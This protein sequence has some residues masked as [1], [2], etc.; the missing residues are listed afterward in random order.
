MFLSKYS[1]RRI[2][3][4]DFRNRGLYKTRGSRSAKS[5]AVYYERPAVVRSHLEEMGYQ[6]HMLVGDGPACG[7]WEGPSLWRLHDLIGNLSPLLSHTIVVI[8]EK[9]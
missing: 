5:V 7:V 8:R 2:I 6:I 3:Q 4:L 9:V 1:L